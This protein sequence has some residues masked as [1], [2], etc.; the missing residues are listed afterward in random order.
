M[1][2]IRL[3]SALL[4]IVLACSNGEIS[5]APGAAGVG[6][7]PS[8]GG[9]PPFGQGGAP[10]NGAGSTAV[11]ARGGG[12]SGGHSGG[13]GSTGVSAGNSGTN[14]GPSAGTGPGGVTGQLSGGGQGNTGG[15]PP[16][17]G[18][19]NPTG[20]A[21]DGG[22][23]AAPHAGST[24]FNG[25]TGGSITGACPGNCR[26]PAAGACTSPQVRITE[27]DLGSPVQSNEDE[28]GLLPLMLA[29]KPGGGSRLA[30]MSGSARNASSQNSTVHVADLDCD[31]HLVGTPFTLAAHDFQ[32][33]AA[34][35]DGG[36]V[37]LTRDGD[38]STADFCGDV[39]NLCKLPTDRPACYNMF[40]VRFDCSGE[41]QWATKLTTSSPSA[42]PYTSGGG[43]NHMI[44]W[45][46]HHG[47]LASDGT[48]YAAY[49]CDAITV[50]NNTCSDKVDIHEGDRMQVVGPNGAVLTGHD[51]FGL[52]CS[53]SWNTRLVWDPSTKHF[54]MVCAT[55]N[56]GRVALP[57]PYR[58]LYTAKTLSTLSVGD[59]VLATGGGYWVTACDESQVHL[60]KFDDITNNGVKVSSDTVIGSA[61]F[62]HLVSYGSEHMVVSWPSGNAISAQ[63]LSAADGSKLGEPFTISVPNNRYTS[64]KSFPDGSV[65]YAAPGTSNTKIRI[66][67]VLPC[68]G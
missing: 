54:V 6:A 39:N 17:G 38:G 53:H 64:F 9:R 40:M 50:T 15:R 67:R 7:E 8:T 1:R 19:G 34:D 62:S 37:M 43:Q 44:W 45:Y 63:V 36:V 14:T 20:G 68:S 48:N 33:I 41:E 30:W 60:L 56:V 16:Q 12:V 46:Q 35:A 65:A 29:A 21:N 23:G 47:R 10:S 26:L 55:D 27:V 11:G 24:S 66:A 13:L 5:P 18:N 42:L 51:S 59:V 32:D 4:L 28:T 52:G 49:F 31:D 61:A 25:G 2:T 22:S 57:A 3:V 58:T